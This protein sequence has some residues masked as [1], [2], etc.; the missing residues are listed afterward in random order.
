[1][2]A[3]CFRIKAM[4]GPSTREKVYITKETGQNRLLCFVIQLSAVMLDPSG[5]PVC[6]RSQPRNYLLTY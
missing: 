2:Y 6:F 3:C 4:G 1:M 5:R